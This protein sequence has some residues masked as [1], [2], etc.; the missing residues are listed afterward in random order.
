M[1]T[2]IY[3]KSIMDSHITCLADVAIQ[4]IECHKHHCSLVIDNLASVLSY[5]LMHSIQ[6]STIKYGCMATGT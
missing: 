5:E 2:G 1:Y 6:P 3:A 4:R